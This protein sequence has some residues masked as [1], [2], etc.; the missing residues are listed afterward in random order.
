MCFL[1]PMG[2][3]FFHLPASHGWGRSISEVK[4]QHCTLET[5][6]ALG[7][8]IQNPRVC[9][10]KGLF[11]PPPSICQ[12]LSFSLHSASLL[13]QCPHFPTMPTSSHSASLFPQCP[14]PPTMPL[15]SHNAPIFPQCLTPLT[16]PPSSHNA[17]ILPQCLTPPPHHVAMAL[18]LA[19]FLIWT[20]TVVYMTLCL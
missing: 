15:F 19:L 5:L 13:P 11:A 8:G 17:P 18:V 20:L 7:G 3:C 10:G 16:M 12:V 6:P 2:T 14:H 4:W 9:L 1:A